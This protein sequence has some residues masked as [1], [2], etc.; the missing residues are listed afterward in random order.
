MTS[1][2]TRR[3]VS[4]A[5]WIE[6]SMGEE[7]AREGSTAPRWNG[8]RADGYLSGWAARRG[9]RGG[10]TARGD[11]GRAEGGE[12]NAARAWGNDIYES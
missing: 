9:T 5:G 12:G 11:V 7:D 10:A 1:I 8:A 3:I 4:R 6:P 2:R